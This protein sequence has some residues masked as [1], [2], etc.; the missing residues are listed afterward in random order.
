[1]KVQVSVAL[2]KFRSLRSLSLSKRVP[3]VEPAPF[4]KLKDR[5]DRRDRR[6]DWS[7]G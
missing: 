6:A 2:R 5:P 1:M 4:D 7:S 3:P